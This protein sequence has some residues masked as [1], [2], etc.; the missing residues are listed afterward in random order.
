MNLLPNRS[1]QYVTIL[2]GGHPSHADKALELV[3]DKRQRLSFI[4]GF[5]IFVV[6]FYSKKSIE[7]IE[8][9]FLATLKGEVDMIFVFPNIKKSVKYMA[10]HLKLKMEQASL[11]RNNAIGSDMA[12][13]RDVLTAIG[14]RMPH[15]KQVAPVDY[16]PIPPREAEEA[17]LSDNDILN[18]MIK[19]MKNTG[20]SSL[21][22]A[23]LDFL[24]SYKDKHR[25]DNQNDQND[26]D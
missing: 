8:E 5:N 24:K 26:V 9:I 25:K 23:E 4:Y 15:M 16:I 12:A 14:N 6:Y 21:T 20:Y 7:D 18:E 11:D 22:P 3:A 1:K 17:S 2:L 10:P 13:F 19:K